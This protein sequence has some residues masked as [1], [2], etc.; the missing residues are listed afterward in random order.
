[1]FC[2]TLRECGENP[3]VEHVVD[4]DQAEQQPRSMVVV[5]PTPLRA[6]E[7]S[8]FDAHGQQRSWR[9]GR[10]GKQTEFR[11]SSRSMDGRRR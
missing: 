3:H 8:P 5:D 9:L 1:V 11:A 7:E 10:R 2:H 6:D 4:Q